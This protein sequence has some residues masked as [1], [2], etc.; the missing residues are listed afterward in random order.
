M[1]KVRIYLT[2][3]DV[4]TQTGLNLLRVRAKILTL[5]TQKL[6]SSVTTDLK[7]PAQR[8]NSD[9]ETKFQLH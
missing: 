6:G 7:K 5:E 3:L 9:L 2:K 8:S 4:C 1:L